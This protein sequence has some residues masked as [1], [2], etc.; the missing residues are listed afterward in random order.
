[1]QD[2]IGKH[3]DR[4]RITEQLGMGGMAVVYKAFDTR[5]E[6]EVA[7]KLIRTESITEDHHS[8]L[9]KRFERE[10]KA[11]GSLHHRN[12]VSVFDYGDFKGIPYLI[13]E[14]ISGKTLKEVEKPVSVEQAAK[15]LAPIAH[16]LEHTHKQNI[17]HRDVKPS[18]ILLTSEGETKLSDFGIAKLLEVSNDG[19]LTGE[20]VGIGTPE[21]MAPEQGLGGTVDGRADMYAL[22]VVFY[23]LVTGVKPFT[24]VTPMAVM[25]KQINDPLPLPTEV[26]PDLPIKIEN[27][28]IKVLAKKPSNRLKDMGEFAVLLDL[29]A[30][31]NIPDDLLT[32]LL[33]IDDQSIEHQPD[34]MQE[35][36]KFSGTEAETW[37]EFQPRKPISGSQQKKAGNSKRN[38]LLVVMIAVAL[39]LF[40]FGIRTL[41]SAFG[42]P[43]GLISDQI[44]VGVSDANSVD[45]NEIAFEKSTANPTEHLP[46][47]E[48]QAIEVDVSLQRLDP[49]VIQVTN[50]DRVEETKYWDNLRANLISWMPNNESFI[51]ANSWMSQGEV[52]KMNKSSGE[53]IDFSKEIFEINSN[54][55]LNIS[56]IS[57]DGSLL[58]AKTY[59]GDEVFVWY[60]KESDPIFKLPG[61]LWGVAHPRAPIVLDNGRIA[62]IINEALQVWNITSGELLQVLDEGYNWDDNLGLVLSPD[63]KKLALL[64]TN[65]GEVKVWDFE[66]FALLQSLRWHTGARNMAFSPDGSL[67]AT[68]ISRNYGSREII[69]IWEV[70]SGMMVMEIQK[71]NEGVHGMIFSADGKLLIT[72]NSIGDV[73]FW[74]IEDGSLLKTIKG[75]DDEPISSITLSHDGKYLLVAGSTDIRL[76]SIN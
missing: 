12:I 52:Y 57:G 53:I 75:Y 39:I 55:F 13:L 1:M 68:G 22:G 60:Y 69:R 56:S 59:G 49:D 9:M 29:I 66:T 50:L 4:Y 35:D 45:T 64:N 72:G 44:E 37:D 8:R 16:A 3:I 24:A 20:G 51:Y 43:Q 48:S 7:L 6:R 27:I 61:Q 42:Y 18:N 73:R 67:I 32:K 46:E 11:L 71:S 36:Q 10:A 15:W 65:S 47:I 34:L 58:A 28:L 5:L 76:F 62:L 33:T 70:E 21:Y 74:H 25:I 41:F 17:L 54:N 2:Y 14:Y 26:A 63:G 38:M 30:K 31:G 23:E 40:V 19:S